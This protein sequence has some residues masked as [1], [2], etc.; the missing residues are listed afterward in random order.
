MVACLLWCCTTCSPLENGS[1][2][3]RFNLCPQVFHNVTA[4][5]T[6]TERKF[7]EACEVWEPCQQ[8]NACFL[9]PRTKFQQ[10]KL[11]HCSFFKLYQPDFFIYIVQLQHHQIQECL[12]TESE[13]R[14][15]V[16]FLDSMR[17]FVMERAVQAC[18]GVLAQR[19]LSLSPAINAATGTPGLSSSTALTS[20]PRPR[21][22]LFFLHICHYNF[23]TYL[24][25]QDF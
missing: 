19:G 21:L 25:L 5:P 24:P 7:L 22:G 23:F 15:F 16:I 3:V 8:P 14:Q 11:R 13:T 12:R 20:R 6:A 1:I 9:S 17:Q 4:V 18:Y 10:L 2:R